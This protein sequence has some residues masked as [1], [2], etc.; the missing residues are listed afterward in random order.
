MNRLFSAMPS[1]MC[2]PRGVLRHSWA[3]TT[4]SSRKTSSAS[5]WPNRPRRLIQ[6]PRL[7][8]TETSGEVVTM[9]RLS[10]LSSAAMAFR[11]LPKPSW[12]LAFLSLGL[13][14][15]AGMAMAGEG[16]ALA[17]DGVGDEAGRLVVVDAFEGVKHGLHVVAGEV[18][19]QPM[20]VG[21]VV[22]LEDAAD[23]R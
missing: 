12:V 19:H 15:A 17:L 1:S 13:G 22:L 23:A 11:I 16:Q 10:S 4:F 9:R 21:I 5:V 3:D 18:G 20:Q 2:W 6:A 7:V 14:S 8:E